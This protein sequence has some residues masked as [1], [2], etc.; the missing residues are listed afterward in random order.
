MSSPSEAVTPALLREWGLPDPGDSKK[1]R[2]EIMVVGGSRSSPGGALLAGEAALR[3]GAGRLGLAVPR[4][5]DAHVGIALPEAGIFALPDDA[6]DPLEGRLRDHVASADAV[7][8]GPGFDDPDETRATLLAV[9]ATGTACLVLDA[10]AI[11][12]LPGV[13]RSALPSRLIL[14]ANKEEAAI[15]LG[16]ELGDDVSADLGEV[17]RRYDAVISCYDVTV[18][19]DGRSWR[20]DEGGPGLGTS[21]SGDVRAGAIAGFAARG[22]PSERAAVWGAWTHARAGDRLTERTGL[23][24]LARDLAAELT[25]TLKDALAPS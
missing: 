16:R 4:S 10:F 9:A 14:N 20:M 5:I 25:P 6:A 23:G 12:V 8:V 1:A 17:A 18:H 13:D 2:G 7:L 15:L 21:G 22:I 24:F 19:P 3:V 11:G